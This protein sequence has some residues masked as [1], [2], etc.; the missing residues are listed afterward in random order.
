MKL[1]D[2]INLLNWRA[3]LKAERSK[4]DKTLKSLTV[5][6]WTVIVFL[7]SRVVRKAALTN[8]RRAPMPY[9]YNPKVSKN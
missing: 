4:M 6:W 3:K 9:F 7:D 1:Q 8:S 5:Q 2:R